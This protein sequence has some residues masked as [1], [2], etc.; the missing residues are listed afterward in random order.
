MKQARAFGVGVVLA[1]QNPVDLDYKALSNAGTWMIGRLQTERDKPRLLD[2]MSAAAGGV[3]V[4]AVGDTIS[5]LAKREFVLRRAGKDQPEV[6][7]TA[8]GDEL[9]ARPADPRPDRQAEARRTVPPRP[10]H[11]GGRPTALRRRPPS[12]RPPPP[13]R[14]SD[15]RRDAGHAGGRRRR[16]R[17]LGRP[18]GAVARR[19]GRRW[20]AG[21]MH[22]A[23]VARVALRYDDEKA[24]L[25]HDEE[26]EAVLSPRST[27]STS[28]GGRRRLRRPRPARRRAEP[29]P[30][31]ADRCADR[32]A[33]F[34]KQLRATS[35]ITSTRSRTLEIPTNVE[36][37]LYGRPGEERRGLHAPAA[38]RPPTSGP[39]PSWRS[40]AT[41][42]RRRRQ[43]AQPDRRRLR[44]RQ[45]AEAQQPTQGATT[46]CRRPDRSSAAC[47]A[48][49]V[50]GAACSA[51][52]AGRPAGPARR[53]R[54]RR[55]EAREQGG[56]P[57]GRLEA[58]EAELA[59][60]LTEIDARWWAEPSRSR[61]CR[62]PRT[63]RR[64]GH[65]PHAGLGS[66][67]G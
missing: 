3:D 23:V 51:S 42:T 58:L 56:P 35:S 7:T 40:C 26:Y 65:Q 25:V 59:E 12:P 32:K 31:P 43:A 20:P 4:G 64:Q 63:H 50:A 60:E 44:R 16:R 36:L 39:T 5:G 27:T 67:R 55:V 14:P 21:P 24:D 61:R 2:G 46:C 57:R 8:L 6:F 62:R 29:A 9:P 47:S 37:K 41:S 30:L 13:P 10:P 54:S 38:G 18:G 34:W 45:V 22:A 28:R 49:A 53:R 33:T 48:G 15:R 17:A 19:V 66:R 1:T 11:P 52:S